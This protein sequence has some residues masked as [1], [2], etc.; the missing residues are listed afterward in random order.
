VAFNAPICVRPRDVAPDTAPADDWWALNADTDLD[1]WG[2]EITDFV[3][4]AALPWA[5]PLLEPDTAVEWLTREGRTW[6]FTHALAVLTAAS[7][8]PVAT[9]TD[10]RAGENTARTQARFA[11][12]VAALTEIW[13][14]DPRP[15]TL[16]PHLAG[17]RREAGLPEVDLPTVWSPSMMPETLARFGS[18]EAARAAGIGVIMYSWDGRTWEDR[19]AR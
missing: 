2:Q 16:R 13:V 7:A 5:V 10:S 17:W 15:I 6:D 11:T 3:T 19:P 18:A 14:A 8:R 9:A 1:R 4:R 12:V